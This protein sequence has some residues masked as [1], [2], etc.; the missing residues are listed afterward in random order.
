MTYDAAVM[1]FALLP[2]CTPV[3]IG[4]HDVP[5]LSF[6]RFSVGSEIKRHI[7]I[8]SHRV[9]TFLTGRLLEQVSGCYLFLIAENRE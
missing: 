5:L 2:F 6:N 9:H 3:L 4:P 8:I 1:C 7:V